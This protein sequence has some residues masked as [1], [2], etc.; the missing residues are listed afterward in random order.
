MYNLSW[1]SK[2]FQYFYGNSIVVYDLKKNKD[3]LF[4]FIKVN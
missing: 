3:I 1:R 4:N 2:S